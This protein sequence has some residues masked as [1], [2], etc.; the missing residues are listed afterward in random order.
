[1]DQLFD[2]AVFHH[3][4]GL[5]ERI[6]HARGLAV[7][8]IDASMGRWMA[9]SFERERKDWGAKNVK[10]LL[11][12]TERYGIDFRSPAG[13]TPLML[14][15]RAQNL[16]LV[17]ALLARGARRDQRDH[18]GRTALSW[19]LR[20]VYADADGRPS[21]LVG[22]LYDLLAPPSFDVEVEGRLHQVGR[23]TAE[24]F[25]FESMLAMHS[26]CLSGRLASFRDFRVSWWDRDGR[27]EGWPDVVL[28]PAR[29]RRT[30]LSSV[31]A[32][33][34][35]DSTYPASKRLFIRMRHGSY[36]IS[37]SLRLRAI[38]PDGSEGWWQHHD[39]NWDAWHRVHRHATTAT[40][41]DHIERT[42]GLRSSTS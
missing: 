38:G 36:W 21:K 12:Q 9:T 30:Y 42:T 8:A 35:V 37:T 14:A 2:F 25:L 41:I 23:E 40:F 27:L 24:Y 26:H 33:Q 7:E 3:E 22:P 29:R 34:E 11:D 32:R 6:G 19:L 5:V 39:L 4:N 18:A 10:G 15:A 20:G 16:P 13:L 28:K 1:M 17:E 31:L